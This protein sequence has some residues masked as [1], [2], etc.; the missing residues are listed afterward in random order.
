M[1]ATVSYT[2]RGGLVRGPM[3]PGGALPRV[4]HMRGWLKQWARAKRR[5]EEVDAAKMQRC[6]SS[7]AGLLQTPTEAQQLELPL[8]EDH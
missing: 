2:M 7:V 1:G 3:Q 6:S 8:D 5:G 4:P